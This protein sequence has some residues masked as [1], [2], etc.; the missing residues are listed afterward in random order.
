MGPI[1]KDRL[2]YFINYEGYRVVLPS[3]SNL[4]R[5]PSPQFQ[6]A[7]LANL[8]ATG[9]AASVPFYQQIFA[10]Y[11]KARASVAPYR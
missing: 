9:N 5:V 1:K 4:I 6:A 11:N 2:F 8:N 3:A 10:I 7:T